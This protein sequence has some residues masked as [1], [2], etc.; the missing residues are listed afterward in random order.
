MG[1]KRVKSWAQMLKPYNTNLIFLGFG[2]DG[3]MVAWAYMDGQLPPAL[4]G[5]LTGLIKAANLGIHFVN[6]TISEENDGGD[7]EADTEAS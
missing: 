4:Y 1:T 7:S 2:L 6:K 5:V 3:L